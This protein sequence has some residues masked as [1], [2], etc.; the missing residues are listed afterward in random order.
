[1]RRIVQ[2]HDQQTR[3]SSQGTGKEDWL[4]AFTLPASLNTATG[5]GRNDV[6]LWTLT[7]QLSIVLADF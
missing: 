3:V 6:L 5:M 4:Y 2:T 1:M 7:G